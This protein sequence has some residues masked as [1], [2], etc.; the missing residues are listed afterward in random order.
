MAEVAKHITSH[1][2]DSDESS[3]QERDSGLRKM[4]K[5]EP[6]PD[7]IGDLLTEFTKLISGI[8]NDSGQKTAQETSGAA[9]RKYP[10]NPLYKPGDGLASWNQNQHQHQQLLRPLK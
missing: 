2:F 8:S 6:K 10:P 4:N 9:E 3:F 1:V 7:E 5:L